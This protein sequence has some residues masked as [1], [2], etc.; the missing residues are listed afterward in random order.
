MGARSAAEGRP[1]WMLGGCLK[2]LKSIVDERRDREAGVPTQAERIAAKYAQLSPEEKAIV[3]AEI[4]RI[5][6]EER[7]Q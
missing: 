4:R 6:A 5:I 1:H 2:G 3:T 7:D